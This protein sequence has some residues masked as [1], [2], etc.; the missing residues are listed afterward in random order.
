MRRKVVTAT[1][2]IVWATLT[3]VFSYVYVM[4]GA[5]WVQV[6]AEYETRWDYRLGFFALSCFPILL[7]VLV[8]ILLVERKYLSEKG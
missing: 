4:L 2:I 7:L 1:T 3:I 8:L 5:G 6:A